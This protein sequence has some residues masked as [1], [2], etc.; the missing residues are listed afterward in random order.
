LVVIDWMT[1]F[2]LGQRKKWDINGN[3][4]ILNND[5]FHRTEEL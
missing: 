4:V 5:S 3:V 2:P 1:I